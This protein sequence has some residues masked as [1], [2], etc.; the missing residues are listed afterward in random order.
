MTT[1]DF[2]SQEKELLASFSG[3]Q[4]RKVNYYFWD[5]PSCQTYSSL[6]WI[7]IIFTDNR[8]LIFHFGEDSSRIEVDHQADFEEQDRLLRERFASRIRLSRENATLREH[9]IDALEMPLKRIHLPEDA[10]G[11][12]RLEWDENYQ[13]D[14]FPALTD[15]LDVEFYEDI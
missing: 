1:E 15:G 13:V 11:S 7:E 5:N 4:V 2:S 8:R 12:I 6:D 14:I 9:W 3:A 10:P